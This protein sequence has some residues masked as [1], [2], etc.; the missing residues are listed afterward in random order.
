[1]WANEAELASYLTPQWLEYVQRP[2]RHLPLRPGLKTYYFVDGFERL[3]AIPPQ[4]GP[5]AS[6]YD[7]LRDQ[8]LEPLGLAHAVLTYN[9]GYQSG[10]DNPYFATALCAAANDWMVQTWLDRDPRFVGSILVA[11]ELPGEAAKEIRR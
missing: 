6:Q 1:T 3:D 10:M 7:L 2:T 11:T 9:V 4:G 8:L 5:A